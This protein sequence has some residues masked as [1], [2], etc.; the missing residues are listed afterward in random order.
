MARPVRYQAAGTGAPPVD[1]L[2]AP[3]PTQLTVVPWIEQNL[4]DTSIAAA[5]E[6]LNNWGAVATHAI[7]STTPGGVDNILPQF[8]DAVG[9]LNL[10]P[11]IKTASQFPGDQFDDPPNTG[12]AVIADKIKEAG[13]ILSSNICLMGT[14]SMVDDFVLQ[15]SNITIDFTLFKSRLDTHLPRNIQYIWYPSVT[16]TAA[17]N[18]D[19]QVEIV[20]AV[21]SVINTS[22]G[23][24]ANVI[25]VDASLAESD[26]PDS[27]LWKFAYT[28]LRQVVPRAQVWR[29][30]RTA[31]SVF[32]EYADAIT[33]LNEVKDSGGNPVYIFFPGIA[34]WVDAS[35]QM[36]ERLLA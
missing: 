11:G 31:A 4:D 8:T 1:I 27:A 30:F 29:L 17:A 3:F 22:N 26:R 18:Q 7:V 33:H 34:T 10:I 32:W 2:T 6:G 19:R 12:W 14:E 9:G 35:E 24:L 25:F 20:E 16:N 13:R 5:I 28:R 23:F 36:S 21:D 15:T